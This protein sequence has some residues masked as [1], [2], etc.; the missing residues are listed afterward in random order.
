MRRKKIRTFSLVLSFFLTKLRLNNG[1]RCIQTEHCV[2][3]SQN[4]RKTLSQTKL[5][6]ILTV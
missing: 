5:I 1:S 2:K 3:S 6:Y 4:G